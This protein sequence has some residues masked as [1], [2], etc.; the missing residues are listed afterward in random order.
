MYI[1]KY[2][3]SF[4]LKIR[5]REANL[6]F[7]GSFPKCCSSSGSADQKLGARNFF[8][9]SHMGAG[10]QGL[11]SFSVASPVYKQG[12]GFEV[13]PLKFKWVSVAD[14]STAVGGLA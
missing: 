5:V 8:K 3:F 13:E 1:L 12:A 10:V 14:A 9:V 11:G 4:Y 6:A 7:A 2:I